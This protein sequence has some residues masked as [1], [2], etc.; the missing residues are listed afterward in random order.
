MG[1]FTQRLSDAAYALL[2]EF[3]V[4]GVRHYVEELSRPEW[5]G[6]ESGVT[7]GIGYDLGMSKA[8]DI[9]SDWTQAGMPQ[10]QVRRLMEVA[11]IT[12]ERASELVGG[13]RDIVIPWSRAWWVFNERTLPKFIRM[14]L[15]TFPESELKMTADGFGALVSLVYNRGPELSGK[16]RVQMRNIRDLIATLP[17]GETLD[18][19]VSRQI[20]DMIPLWEGSDIEEGMRR[21]RTAEA[22]LVFPRS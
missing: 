4:G 14:T 10:N 15:R 17:R 22:A 13:I 5:P 21:R 11:G 16:R 12:G 2:I 20:L 9:E 18:R 6:Y 7:V 3:E 1:Q 19:S 8:E